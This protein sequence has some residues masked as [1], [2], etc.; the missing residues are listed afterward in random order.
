M[1]PASAL[2]VAH[3]YAGAASCSP[4]AAAISRSCAKWMICPPAPQLP[5]AISRHVTQTRVSVYSCG[6]PN[7]SRTAFVAASTNSARRRSDSAPS[8]VVASTR[9]I[10]AGTGWPAA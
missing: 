1:E 7:A 10:G 2:G 8:G 5:S 3:A 4:A 9:T 6:M